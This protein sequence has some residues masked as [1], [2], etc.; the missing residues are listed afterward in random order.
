[1]SLQSTCRGR[2]WRLIQMDH[3][4]IQPSTARRILAGCDPLGDT[5]DQCLKELPKLP[6]GESPK[7]ALVHDG[8]DLFG[9]DVDWLL[10]RTIERARAHP[11]P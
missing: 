1:M 5:I 8:M 10:A 3:P 7:Y 2:G 6:P 4:F 11:P 9:C